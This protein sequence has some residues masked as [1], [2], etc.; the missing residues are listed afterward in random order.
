MSDDHG[1]D[2]EHGSDAEWRGFRERLAV[3]V[4]RLQRG[5]FVELSRSELTGRPLLIVTVTGS[6]RVRITI[7]STALTN[8]WS[9]DH[10]PAAR[11][12]RAA[13]ARL[14]WR[15]LRS[16]SLIRETGRRRT[17]ELLGEAEAALRE[18]WGIVRPSEVHLRAPFGPGAE[19]STPPTRPTD[20]SVTLTGQ[21]SSGVI[22]DDAE[23]LLTMAAD[24]LA[25]VW[26]R[27]VPTDDRAI[28]FDDVDGL[29]TKLLVSPHAMRLEFCTIVGQWTPDLDLLGAVVAEHSSRY[30][31]VAILVAKDHVFAVRT[32]DCAVFIP[33]NL[34]ATMSAWRQFCTEGAIDIIEQLHPEMS[35]Q[36]GPAP[37]ELS[38]E[39]VALIRRFDAASVDLTPDRLARSARANTPLLRRYARQCTGWLELRPDAQSAAGPWMPS[40]DAVRRFLPVLL[41]AIGI[42]AD[43]N[44]ESELR[45]GA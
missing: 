36:F 38:A 43:L 6:G 29:H 31:D 15:K 44:V 28:R 33:A 9:P 37:G 42:A 32:L 1:R 41:E 16:G 35:G 12:R 7:E 21:P 3:A 25:A 13:V 18:V 30:P 17:D 24:T 40:S 10:A 11:A 26:G 27:D 34:L 4:D 2:S 8:L 14:G 20:R 45:R 22:P 19:P 5:E 39:L 23:H